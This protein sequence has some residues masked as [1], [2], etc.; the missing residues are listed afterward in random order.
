M[1]IINPA[2]QEIIQ[3]VAEDTKEIIAQK[4]ERLRKGQPAWAAV[5]VE[6]RIAIIQKFYDLLDA[7]K[8]EL[9]KTLT[10]EMGKPLQQSYN[11]LNGARS[12][13][14]FF[15]DNSSKFWRLLLNRLAYTF[16]M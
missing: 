3:E 6:Q 5:S 12:R 7:E 16:F 13:I 15:I 9:A 11:E 8:D 1:T 4:Y 2:T 14:K 10:S